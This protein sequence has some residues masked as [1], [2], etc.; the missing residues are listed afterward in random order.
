M[1]DLGRTFRQERL[2]MIQLT[3]FEKIGASR[4]LM[5]V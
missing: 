2:E 5:G 4:W 3:V 1:K